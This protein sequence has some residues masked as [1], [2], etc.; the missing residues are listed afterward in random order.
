MMQ[1]EIT[2]YVYSLVTRLSR[3]SRKQ[4]P[5]EESSAD[6]A[7]MGLIFHPCE[8]GFPRK[9]RMTDIS[10]QL[11]ISKP[12]ATQ[13]VNRLVE[14]GLAERIRDEE[15]RRVVYIQATQRGLELFESRLNQRLSVL[16]KAIDRIGL[17]KA[18][19]LGALLDEFVDAVVSVSED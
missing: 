3:A 8:D 15:D 19:Q 11:M 13:A 10:Q 18:Q 16:E 6:P 4:F 2:R 1:N 12:A 7:M 14:N 5:G 17:D 9:L